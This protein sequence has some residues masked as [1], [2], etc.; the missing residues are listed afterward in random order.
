VHA[1][2]LAPWASALAFIVLLAAVWVPEFAHWYVHPAPLTTA[3]VDAS[4]RAPLDATLDEVAGQSLRGVVV[5]LDQVVG[6]AEQ[7]LAGTLV[8]PTFPPAPLSHPFDAA[9]LLHGTSMWQLMTASLASVDVLLDGHIATRRPELFQRARDLLVGFARDESRRWLDLGLLWNDHAISARVPVLAKF[10]R[11]QRLRPPDPQAEQAVMRLAARSALQLAKPDAYAWRTSHGILADLALL[12]V[13]AAFPDLPEAALARRVGAE[14]FKQHLDYWIAGDGVTLLHSAGYHAGSLY[15]LSVGLR[16]FSLNNLPVPDEWWRRYDRALHYMALLRRPDG[17][18]PMFG[19]TMSLG[20]PT[21]MLLTARDADGR[22]APVQPRAL[23][24]PDPTAGVLLPVSGSG[25][26]WDRGGSDSVGSAGQT[27]ATWAYHRGLGHKLAD[28]MSVL[29]WSHGRNWVSNT[30]YWP[31]D[32]AGRELAEGWDASNAPHLV[33][34]RRD[35]E[36]STRVTG[37]ASAPGLLWLALERRGP[38]GLVLRRQLLRLAGADSW[39]VLDEADEP[40]GRP[41]TT[42]W[43]LFPDLAVQST[44]I[45]DTHLVTGTLGQPRLQVTLRAPTGQ[46]VDTLRGSRQP[47]GGWVVLE[48]TPQPATTLVREQPASA[49]WQLAVFTVLPPDAGAS[50]SGRTAAPAWRWTDTRHWQLTLTSARG[51][52]E[53]R[54]DGDRLHHT[55]AAAPPVTL[56]LQAPAAVGPADAGADQAAAIRRAYDQ[57]AATYRRFPEVLPY[58]VRISK[59]A[60]G[61]LMLQELALFGLGRFRPAAAHRLRWLAAAAWLAAAWWLL[62]VY[63]APR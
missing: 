2:R 23:P 40:R 56:A 31:Y 3:V 17:T 42:R 59:L 62:A 39:V 41:W 35:S 58:R 20:V 1:A 25:V 29:F 13:A 46:P 24:V 38:D 12:Q 19:D 51:D 43:T 63:F 11:L 34:E 44:T 50:A 33:G 57:A 16:L 26:W 47:W 28:E 32:F 36:R 54:R 52:I 22:A 48:R 5:P 7:A 4:R 10:W 6:T 18:L 49:A 9:D 55:A 60:L 53:L 27:V 45:A 37:Q 8:L 30:G 15:H 21:P 61:G 14:R